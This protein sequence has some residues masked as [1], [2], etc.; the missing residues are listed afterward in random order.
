LPQIIFGQNLFDG[1]YRYTPI[2]EFPD[3]FRVNMK[4]FTP[5]QAITLGS[6]TYRVFPVVN[7]DTVNTVLGDEYSGYEGYAYRVRP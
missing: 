3:V 5:A 4:G 6:D 1:I 2:G 7:S